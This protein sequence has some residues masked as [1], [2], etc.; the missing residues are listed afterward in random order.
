MI[1]Q[2][3]N[4]NGKHLCTLSE[5]NPLNIGFNEVGIMSAKNGRWTIHEYPNYFSG[6]QERPVNMMLAMYENRECTI[7]DAIL[8]V[9]EDKITLDS[10]TYN[11]Q[12]YTEEVINRTKKGNY[13]RGLFFGF[14]P[15]N[16]I[17]IS[18]LEGIGV[19]RDLHV[20]AG[21]IIAT[22]LFAIIRGG[23][24]ASTKTSDEI[25]NRNSY[26]ANEG[27]L[28]YFSS[29]IDPYWDIK[30]MAHIQLD[31]LNR[32]SKNGHSKKLSRN[33]FFNE[34]LPLVLGQNP[35]FLEEARKDMKNGNMVEL[36]KSIAE[37]VV[38]LFD[39]SQLTLNKT[40]S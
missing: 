6:L 27:V 24:I 35:Q 36:G 5:I 20:Y 13:L 31:Y 33:Q 38:Y 34:Y 30:K 32:C 21:G 28:D 9:S 15:M 26:H 4:F 3:T 11:V 22:E 8:N 7:D 16:I 29:E 40:K 37:S 39:S 18:L 2:K 19:P 17:G 14:I 25:F 23:K 12:K 1:D 10:F